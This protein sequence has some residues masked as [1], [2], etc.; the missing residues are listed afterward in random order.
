[1]WKGILPK[2]KAHKASKVQGTLSCIY[3][4]HFIKMGCNASSSMHVTLRFI[5]STLRL[6]HTLHHHNAYYTSMQSQPYHTLYIMSCFLLSLLCT[7]L[8][9]LLCLHVSMSPAQLCKSNACIGNAEQCML[10]FIFLSHYTVL[11]ILNMSPAQLC[12]TNACMSNAEQCVHIH[13][14][15]VIQLY[16]LF[17]TIS[18]FYMCL[19]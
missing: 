16:Q 7:L 3:I 19:L 4:Y 17:C 5:H 18:S 10:A 1:M 2:V 11:V 9:V 13:S 15:I 6:M 12:K 8:P 14:S